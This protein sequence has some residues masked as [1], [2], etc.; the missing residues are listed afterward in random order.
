M[1][2]SSGVLP[3]ASISAPTILSSLKAS[4]ILSACFKNLVGGQPRS[5][6]PGSTVDSSIHASQDVPVHIAE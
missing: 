5:I 6:F 1:K 2:A 3:A 4:S